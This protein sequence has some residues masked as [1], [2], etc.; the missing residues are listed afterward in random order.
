MTSICSRLG[1]KI[2]EPKTSTVTA[3]LFA[4]GIVLFVVSYRLFGKRYE[5]YERED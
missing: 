2:Q 1:D 3:V 5:E 4:I